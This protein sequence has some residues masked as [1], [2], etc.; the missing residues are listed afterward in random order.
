LTSEDGQEDATLVRVLSVIEKLNQAV[1]RPGIDDLQSHLSVNIS[2]SHMDYLVAILLEKGYLDKILNPE[3]YPFTEYAI[4]LSGSDFLKRYRD[5][6]QSFAVAAKHLS[7][8]KQR[9]KL[10]THISN[11]RNL[12]WFAYYDG[13][14]TK[15]D[16]RNF[17]DLLEMEMNRFFYGRKSDIWADFY[18]RGYG[19]N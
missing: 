1:K 19:M 11:N 2:R 3:R 4:T 10:Y 8:N 16:L 14:L 17:R 18:N 9:G 6:V 15:K 5:Q 13:I 7:K 12:F